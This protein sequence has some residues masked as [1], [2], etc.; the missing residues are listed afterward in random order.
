MKLQF[1]QQALQLYNIPVADQELTKLYSFGQYETPPQGGLFSYTADYRVTPRINALYSFVHWLRASYKATSYDALASLSG[2]NYHL[3]YGVLSENQEY[4]I[5]RKLPTY[6]F[7]D[8]QTAASQLELVENPEP[9]K[10]FKFGDWA[11]APSNLSEDFYFLDATSFLVVPL[12]NQRDRVQA[13]TRLSFEKISKREASE[14]NKVIKTLYS[15]LVEG[16]EINVPSSPSSYYHLSY[17]DARGK[18]AGFSLHPRLFYASFLAGP[19]ALKQKVSQ[20]LMR[21]EYMTQVQEEVAPTSFRSVVTAALAKEQALLAEPSQIEQLTDRQWDEF[22][23]HC[24]Q[25]RTEKFVNKLGVIAGRLEAVNFRSC[26][27][28]LPR[29]ESRYNDLIK[30]VVFIIRLPMRDEYLDYYQQLDVGNLVLPPLAPRDLWSRRDVTDVFTSGQ[31]SHALQQD[32]PIPRLTS[33]VEKFPAILPQFSSLAPV[34]K[35]LKALAVLVSQVSQV[36]AR[37]VQELEERELL[38]LPNL[39][40]TKSILEPGGK[41]FTAK[42]VILSVT[43]LM[44][45]LQ[46]VVSK[47]SEV[48]KLS[49]AN[50]QLPKYS[51]KTPG[52]VLDDIELYRNAVKYEN[53]LLSI[54][55]DDDINGFILALINQKR[56]SINQEVNWDAAVAAFRSE[57]LQYNQPRCEVKL[58]VGEVPIHVK[59]SPK[60]L[61]T[62]NDI[63]INRSELREVIMQALCFTD[64]KVYNHFLASVRKC[65][66]AVHNLLTNGF[67]LSLKDDIIGKFSYSIQL[68]IVRERNRNYLVVDNQRYRISNTPKLLNLVSSSKTVPLTHFLKLVGADGFLSESLPLDK[69]HP[70]IMQ[71]RQKYID[72]IEKSKLL[73]EKVEKTFNLRVDTYRDNTGRVVNG[74]KINGTSGTEYILQYDKNEGHQQPFTVFRQLG[75]HLQHVCIV[76]KSTDQAGM[77]KLINRIYALHN[78]KLV[79]HQISTLNL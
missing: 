20:R 63:R 74:Y 9:H 67:V 52:V 71:S 48:S 60:G 4:F 44:A 54:D 10:S 21:A 2:S 25:S 77:D 38:G 35:A 19:G 51:D 76:D 15:Q 29:L 37:S 70:L 72:A 7:G 41:H 40:L 6:Q 68:P 65:S 12:F 3:G 33:G 22:E 11:E 56:Y 26:V 28:I 45:E 42:Q 61:L 64:V 8:Q 32:R 24:K 73:L 59:V 16:K 75:D 1:L 79:A 57:L 36:Q 62:V 14:V 17:S 69:L 53:Q 50:E 46:Q 34:A 23:E 5:I 43:S 66:L 13:A 78:D 55:S 58:T 49:S 31:F 18:F 47:Y 27:I 30:Y 39:D